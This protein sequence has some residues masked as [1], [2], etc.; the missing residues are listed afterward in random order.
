VQSWVFSALHDVVGD[1]LNEF[2]NHRT[3][4]D[5]DNADIRKKAMFTFVNSYVSFFYLA[6]VAG[7]QILVLFGYSPTEGCAGYHT[8][9]EALSFNLNAV[10][11]ANLI[12]Q[13]TA[14]FAPCL[15]YIQSSITK[16][17]LGPES[18]AANALDPDDA[19]KPYA[20]QYY[21]YDSNGQDVSNSGK[22]ADAYCGFFKQFGYLMF[23]LPA[24]PLAAIIC[25]VA[26]WVEMNGDM[27]DFASALRTLPVGAQDIGAWGDCFR[28]LILLAVPINSALVIFTMDAVDPLLYAI[29]NAYGLNSN[30]L[31]LFKLQ[32]FVVLQYLV[33]L[34]ISAINS[35]VPDVDPHLAVVSQRTTIVNGNLMLI[36]SVAEAKL[37]ALNAAAKR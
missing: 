21:N 15:D 7:N 33:F 20:D 2:E 17:W 31:V 19:L 22:L 36:D 24:Y 4:D 28:T 9:M 13:N 23:F 11:M 5:Y 14:L 35:I 34:I 12:A 1:W 27:K 32:V 10:L 26:N 3:Q 16:W 18:N 6:F 29:I 8:C 25:F 30:L 37:K